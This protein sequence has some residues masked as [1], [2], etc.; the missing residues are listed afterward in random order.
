MKKFYV[1]ATAILL[2]SLAIAQPTFSWA[3]SLGGSLADLSNKVTS[4][5]SGNVLLCGGFSSTNADFDPGP[6]ITILTALG[7]NDIHVT[8]LDAAG[9]LVW[10]K[11]ISSSLDE[12]AYG[13]AADNSGN[14]LVTGYF[15]GTVDFDPGVGTFTLASNGS[16]D[17]FVLK[18]SSAGNFVWAVSMGSGSSDY[19]NQLVCDASGNVYSTGRYVGTVD[20]DPSASTSTLTS[21]GG[22]DIYVLK[23]SSAGA[24]VWA[25]SM[26]S[27]GNDEG[28]GI[29]LDG[30]GNVHTT[31]SFNGI[32]DFDPGAGTFTLNTFGS[33]DVFVSKLDNSGNFMLAVQMGG[34]SSDVGE[35]IKVDASGNIHTGGTISGIA[36]FDPGNGTFNLTPSGLTG[37]FISK[38]SSVG[39]F[40]WAKNFTGGSL[41]TTKDIDLDASGNVY[42][43]GQ[44]NGTTDLDP[45]AGSFTLAAVGAYDGYI[46]VLTSSGNYSWAGAISGTGQD[47]PSGIRVTASSIYATG[48]YNQTTDFDASASTSTIT[49]AG[50]DDAF[51]VKYNN[52]SGAPATPSAISG[53][54]VICGMGGSATYTAA[55]VAGASSY[56]WTLSAGVVGSSTSNVITVTVNAATATLSVNAVNAC[57]MS[58]AQSKTV[59][60]DVSTAS[61]TTQNIC[62]N[63][64]CTGAATINATGNAPFTYTWIPSGSSS[65]VNNLC[66]GNYT[67]YFG[68]NSGCVFTKTF[69][70]TQ[71]PVL[72][73]TISPSTATLCAGGCANLNANASGGL[74]QYTY[75]WSPTTSTLSFATVCPSVTSV[76]TL[77]LKD[78]C[79]TVVLT[80]TVTVNSCSGI[81]ENNSLNSEF[82]IYPNPAKNFVT[83]RTNVAKTKEARIINGIGQEVMRIEL[84]KEQ[85]HI[86]VSKL[87]KGIY[88]VKIDDVISK[89]VIE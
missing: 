66:A 40:V 22:A 15:N 51:V 75:T 59:S 86:D 77:T 52:C 84:T 81:G 1:I 5:A 58:A 14:V 41:V 38:L 47:L 71:P 30:T 48:Y 43:T 83:I 35:S 69:V 11:A 21:A 61:I 39:A 57:G 7:A 82:T 10:A 42:S 9:N 16:N 74:G 44:F 28:K 19:G 73:V 25:K 53:P 64:Q 18:L 78:T 32:S 72:T 37:N 54:G 6:G 45:N 79:C 49:S 68:S 27:G 24:L 88:F 33:N 26:G 36:D 50:S 56:S 3:K 80:K 85:T 55:A 20:F 17:I 67:V 29:A 60:V 87:S 63:G 76:Y 31:G 65:T 12:Q 8:K 2:S 89:L 62:C 13:I 4:D 70:I 34:A 46:S 23:L